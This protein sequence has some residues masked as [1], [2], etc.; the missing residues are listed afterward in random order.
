MSNAILFHNEVYIL[1]F[2]QKNE[3]TAENQFLAG[4]DCIHA[5]FLQ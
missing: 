1:S 2:K 3:F 5:G 4:N